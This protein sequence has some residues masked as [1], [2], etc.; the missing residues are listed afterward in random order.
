[1]ES[2][3]IEDMDIEVLSSMWPEDVG[4]DIGK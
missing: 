3:C 1:M 2:D 4:T